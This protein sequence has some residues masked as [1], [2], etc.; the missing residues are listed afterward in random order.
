[1]KVI[2]TEKSQVLA[3][4]IAAALGVA[5]AD[6]KFARFPDGELYLAA[7]ALDDETV[8]VGSVTD[9][10]GLIVKLSGSKVHLA[11]GEPREFYI[12]D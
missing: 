5:T 6:V 1:M 7:G 3:A 10:D 8:I 9:N 4:R 11:I 2:S 12:N